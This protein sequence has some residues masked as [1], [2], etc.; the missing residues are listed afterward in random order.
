MLVV[1]VYS[2]GRLPTILH[3]HLNLFHGVT[4]LADG[5]G[6][7]DGGPELQVTSRTV[8]PGSSRYTASCCVKFAFYNEAI[9]RLEDARL[10]VTTG[11][12]LQDYTGSCIVV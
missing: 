8:G 9:L 2:N 3:L 7:F 11:V 1:V 4:H 12:H 6:K 5:Y 10:D